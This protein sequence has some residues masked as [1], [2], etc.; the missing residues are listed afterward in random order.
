M[1]NQ[2][3]TTSV[4]AAFEILIEEIEADIDIVSQ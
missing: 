3:N 2:N 4:F 1:K